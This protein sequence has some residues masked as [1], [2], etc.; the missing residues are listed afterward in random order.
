MQF[1]VSKSVIYSIFGFVTDFINWCGA[2]TA[3]ALQTA[4]PPPA[5]AVAQ[6]LRLFWFEFQQLRLRRFWILQFVADYSFILMFD[7]NFAQFIVNCHFI[8]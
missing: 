3:T 6:S 7:S 8:T 5:G 4:I 1:G 2:A